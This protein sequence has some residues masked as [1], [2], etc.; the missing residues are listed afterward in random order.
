M[1]RAGVLMF[2][3]NSLNACVLAND[4]ANMLKGSLDLRHISGTVPG[5]IAICL[6]DEVV[7]GVIQLGDGLHNESLSTSFYFAEEIMGMQYNKD[8]R[9]AHR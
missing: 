8:R 1:A 3:R 2:S 5:Y 9:G 4:G 6:E 7:D